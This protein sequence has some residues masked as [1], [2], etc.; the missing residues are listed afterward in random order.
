MVFKLSKQTAA[1]PGLA[2]EPASVPAAKIEIA[3]G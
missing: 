1:A 3:R 2:V